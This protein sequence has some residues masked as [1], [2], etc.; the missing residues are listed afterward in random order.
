MI[1]LRA[2]SASASS[3]AVMPGR[4][5][6]Q[7]PQ[8]SATALRASAISAIGGG[9]S[10]SS[11]LSWSASAARASSNWRSSTSVSTTART[12][13][14]ISQGSLVRV[15]WSSA[16]QRVTERKGQPSVSRRACARKKRAMTAPTRDPRRGRRR[17]GAAPQGRP[18]R[19]ADRGQV[20]EPAARP[21]PAL[22]SRQ[23]RLRAAAGAWRLRAALAPS[24]AAWSRA[25]CAARAPTPG[26]CGCSCAA[27][28]APNAKCPIPEATQAAL[29]RLAER[30]PARARPRAARRA[31]RVRP[32]RPLP[33]AEPPSRCPGKPCTSSFAPARW[34][35]A[36][37]SGSRTR[38]RCGPTGPPRCSKTA[39]RSTAS[40][41]ASATPIC[42][43]PAATPPITRTRSTTSP[44]SSIAATKRHAEPALTLH[45]KAS[46]LA[47]R[48]CDTR[49]GGSYGTRDIALAP[50][51]W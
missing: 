17:E 42:A 27:R 47:P 39:C 50:T 35:P 9:G 24:C 11:R 51:T 10:R 30:A 15:A 4:E 32:S 12:L 49:S 33:G 23:A 40:P 21:R 13:I 22:G 28:A 31:A 46:R 7:Y 29:A 3:P 25:T 19:D 26:T 34:P 6:Q 20:R 38:T 18:A 16:D 45:P 37:P 14:G 36:C 43:P 48:H 5:H 41:A 2:P 44:T 8:A 1:G